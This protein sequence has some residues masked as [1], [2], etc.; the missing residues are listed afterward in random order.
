MFTGNTFK[1]VNLNTFVGAQSTVLLESKIQC[2][3]L[4]Y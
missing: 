2:R 4:Q 3:R 1:E